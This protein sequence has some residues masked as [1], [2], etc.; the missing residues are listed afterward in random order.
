MEAI[1]CPIS[2]SVRWMSA[3][4]RLGEGRKRSLM[5]WLL[6]AKI[7]TDTVRGMASNIA[8]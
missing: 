1:A 2:G 5:R 6:A 8:F 4:H 3:R 7:P